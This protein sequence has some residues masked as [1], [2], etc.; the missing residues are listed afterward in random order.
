MTDLPVLGHDALGEIAA[1]CTRAIVDAPTA[2]E[3]EGA[4]FA[5]EQPAVVRG[6]PAVGVVATV[7][8][9][10]GAYVRLLAVDPAARGQG[11]GHAL[12]RAAQADAR[13]FASGTL[14]VGAD[15]PFFLWPGVPSTELALLCLLERHHYG[16]VETNF[17]M[18]V[19]LAAIP[20][21]PGGHT[22]AALAD[23]A[24][25]DTWM[26]MHWPHWRLEVLRALDKG[27]LVLA[28]TAGGDIGAICAFEVNRSGFLGPVAARPDLIGQGLGRPA[29]LGALHELRRRGKERVQVAWVGPILPYARVGGRVSN[30]YFVYRRNLT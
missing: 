16:R 29:L 18:T 14:T 13:A 12:L 1:L 23:R 24:E 7:E 26:A 25:V 2:K 19:E 3:L 10:D 30:V 8:G 11:H 27:N 9:S 28:R 6:D 21:D 5:P 4:L 20:D 17:D 15:A 22:L